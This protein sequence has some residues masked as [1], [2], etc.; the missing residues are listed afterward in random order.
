ML[1]CISH[2]DDAQN[3]HVG[4]KCCGA[5]QV[6]ISAFWGSNGDQWPANGGAFEYCPK[7]SK[8]FPRQFPR[9]LV[10]SIF[11]LTVGLPSAVSAIWNAS[12]RKSP[13]FP[14]S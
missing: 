9:I 3:A 7:W 5:F 10:G 2:S 4:S 6:P 14:H 11:A 1:D 8:R 12:A 13:P